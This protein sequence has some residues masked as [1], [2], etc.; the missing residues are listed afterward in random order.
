MIRLKSLLNESATADSTVMTFLKARGLTTAQAAGIAGNLQQES[1]F[2]PIADNNKKSGEFGEK[3]ADGTI[4]KPKGHFGIAQ[5]DKIIRW[6]KVKKWMKSNNHA[7][8][9]LSGQLNAL[10]W[11][12]E[13]RD[14][15]G[16]IILTKTPEQA[17]AAWLKHF[18]L[19]GEGP[20][21][22]GYKKRVEY[23]NELYN[24][25]K[26]TST[27]TSKTSQ[28]STTSAWTA[29]VNAISKLSSNKTYTVKSGDS[30]SRIANQNK[31]T[32]AAIK[33]AN[34]GIDPN[35]LK[36]GQKIKLP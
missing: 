16:E 4:A 32:V 29:A 3:R 13:D 1:G 33:N 25:F 17:A 15:W 23:A 24:K 6:P 2:S 10:K 20:D 7:P 31:T 5:W 36:I 14:D 12:A 28:S 11:E 21:S 35:K 30:L 18:E 34:P 19:S 27:T 26:K 8:Y 9:S 22:S